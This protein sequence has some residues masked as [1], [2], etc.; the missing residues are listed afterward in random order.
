M[1]SIAY[2]CSSDRSKTW[3]KDG[4]KKVIVCIISDGRNE[5]NKQTL[6]LLA[7]VSA[8]TFA[9]SYQHL[10]S[11]ADGLLQGRNC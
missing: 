10:R 2:L 7:Q 3:D 6:Q 1:K 9:L 11:N 5:A 8:E 4:W